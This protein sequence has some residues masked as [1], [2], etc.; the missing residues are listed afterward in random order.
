MF[1]DYYFDD[2]ALQGLLDAI[3]YYP[4]IIEPMPMASPIMD[5][6][7]PLIAT[8]TAAPSLIDIAAAAPA[9]PTP[10]PVEPAPAPMTQEDREAR[11]IAANTPPLG[12]SIVGPTADGD[13]LAFGTGN[14]FNVREGQEV[15]LV[16]AG[17]NV[18]VSGSGVEGANQAV[19]AA[20][21]LSDELG[22]NANFKIQT[23]ER[24]I[25]PDGSVG[26]NRYI[27]VARAAPSQSGL[28]FLADYVL[29]FAASFIPGVGPVLGAALGSG[30]SSAA[31]GRDLEDALKRAALA[32]GTAYVGGQVFGPTT[33]TAPTPPADSVVSA[34]IPT[35]I[36]STV[37]TTAG[38]IVVNAPSLFGSTV[39]NVIGS[40]VPSLITAPPSAPVEPPAPEAAQPAPVD[41][42][43]VVSAAPPM[44][45]SGLPFA[46]ALPVPVEALLSGVL[47]AAQ[48]APAQPLPEQQP[49]DD[50][51]LVEARKSFL[52]PET[53]AAAPIVGGLLAATGG[54]ASNVV[55]GIDQATGDIVVNAP[56]AVAAPPPIPG[57]ETAIP[58]ITG[59]ALTAAQTAG[60]PP[61]KDKFDFN[62]VLGTGLSLP[63]LLSIGGIGADL[64]KNLLAGGGTG[65]TTPY[66]SPFGTG[67]GFGTGRDMRANPTIMDYERYG[68]GPEAMFFQP[69]YG[70]L[71]A[72]A[73]PQAQPIMAAPQAQPAMVTNPRYEPLI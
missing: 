5:V 54:G 35:S 1:E 57:F 37:G 72:G 63:Q 16:D 6:Q 68:F 21:S 46:S 66:V 67:V 36:G 27:D 70:L 61:S 11:R 60:T 20:Q 10:T 33:P 2:P 13:P 30:A 39:G 34:S 4:Q 43:I 64:L 7:A 8:P 22:G 41:D 17:G 29:P 32:A 49:V 14:T 69:G 44:S 26:E 51:I 52:P 12:T 31:Q 59:G 71:S 3:G 40:T 25:N 28:G 56:Q 65:P 38:E 73:A 9:E 42:T 47:A 45:G 53:L 55:E 58:A 48:P 50:E 15:R 23:G 18:I 19:A 24:T 62:D